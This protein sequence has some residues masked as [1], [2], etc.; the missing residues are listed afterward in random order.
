MFQTQGSM[1]ELSP[2]PLYD[3]SGIEDSRPARRLLLAI[4]RRAVLDYALYRD[5]DPRHQKR[6]RDIAIDA[7]DWMFDDDEQPFSLER[8]YTFLRVCALL[9]L[10]PEVVRARATILTREEIYRLQGKEL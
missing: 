8:G 10:D 6:Q 9:G 2:S 3:G 5:C 4:I 1:A 7:R